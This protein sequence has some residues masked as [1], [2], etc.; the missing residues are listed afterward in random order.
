MMEVKREDII[1]KGARFSLVTSGQEVARASLF[2][3]NND[4]HDSPFGFLED[5][6]VKEEFRG[7][8][9]GTKI[10]KKVI[11][12]AK[13]QGCYKLVANSRHDRL[14]VHQLYQNLGFKDH[15]KEFRL[16]L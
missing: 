4:S 7:Q 5:V 3:L 9:L 6:F 8:G 1:K 13:S 10:V 15:G 16:D 12:E 11:E 14:E 2:I